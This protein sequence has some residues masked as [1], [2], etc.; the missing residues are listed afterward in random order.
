MTE[1]DIPVAEIEETTRIHHIITCPYCGETHRHGNATSLDI[2]DR[3][4]RWSHCA[5]DANGYYL[6]RTPQTKM[7]NVEATDD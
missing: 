5:A 1:S 4:H 7:W 3:G 2:G 6:E